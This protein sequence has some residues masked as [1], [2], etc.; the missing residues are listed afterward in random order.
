MPFG[1]EVSVPSLHPLRNVLVLIWS[2]Y[3]LFLFLWFFM[4]TRKVLCSLFLSNTLL[5]ISFIYWFCTLRS[6]ETIKTQF[7][8][9]WT[10]NKCMVYHFTH[11]LVKSWRFF[12]RKINHVSEIYSWSRGLVFWQKFMIKYKSSMFAS[13]D[14]CIY[15]GKK[16]WSICVVTPILIIPIQGV[17]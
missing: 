11:I 3:L 10:C 12:W 16:T 9:N 7:I 4:F 13:R 6:F 17:Y 14:V 5:N 15:Y 8:L 2:N 1:S